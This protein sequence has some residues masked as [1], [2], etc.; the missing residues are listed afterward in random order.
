MYDIG[1]YLVLAYKE[2]L[3]SS[4]IASFLAISAG[5]VQDISDMFGELRQ[6]SYPRAFSIVIFGKFSSSY[7]LFS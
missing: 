2:R 1:M 3:I 4:V 5:A 6:H 7:P